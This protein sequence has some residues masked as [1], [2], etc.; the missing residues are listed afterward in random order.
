[1]AVNKSTSKLRIR[2]NTCS[3]VTW[4]ELLTNK[5]LTVTLY[6]QDDEAFGEGR[7]QWE[8]FQ[9][10]GC[11][12]ISLRVTSDYP[13]Q[14]DPEIHFFPERTG[15]HH[16]KKHYSK[17]PKKLTML[18]GETIEAYN[19]GSLLLCTA[20]IRALLEGLCADK[21]ITKGPDR[22]GKIVKNLEG[23]INGLTSIVPASIVKN[24]HGLRFLGNQAV[25]ELEA[26][27]KYDLELALTVIEDILNVVYDLDY[28]TQM[29]YE[30]ATR[31][32]V[33]DEDIPF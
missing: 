4:H 2:C 5:S 27:S 1:M 21:G 15:D 25:H 33:N 17:L 9:C 30:M 32:K 13:W 12:S 29:L 6:G 24:L 22:D 20:G 14:D 16:K 26:P 31:P 11:D 23:K 28:R 3:G 8:L 10:S 18:Y 7:E 19:R